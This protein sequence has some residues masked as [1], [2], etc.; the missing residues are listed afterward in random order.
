MSDIRTA[1]KYLLGRPV[2]SEDL[3]GKKNRSR[4]VCDSLFF[5]FT[6]EEERWKHPS[7]GCHIND[8][9][10]SDVQI[11]FDS[12]L[13][14]H[15]CIGSGPSRRRLRCQTTEQ[16]FGKHWQHPVFS[17]SAHFLTSSQTFRIFFFCWGSQMTVLTFVAQQKNTDLPEVSAADV[18]R[19]HW[20][21]TVNGFGNYS[22]SSMR[23]ASMGVKERLSLTAFQNGSLESW[24]LCVLTLRRWSHN[25]CLLVNFLTPTV[26]IFPLSP[27]LFTLYITGFIFSVLLPS[28][29]STFSLCVSLS[30]AAILPGLTLLIWVQYMW[31]KSEAGCTAKPQAP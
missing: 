13:P 18:L 28:S 26:S 25:L 14:R 23:T 7:L 29:A 9:I 2:L 27:R 10:A 6:P 20:N 5:F 16:S 22:M 21:A 15:R 12:E 19:L 1:S 30:Y 31:L 24:P 17:F 3:T 4:C 11:A 8:T